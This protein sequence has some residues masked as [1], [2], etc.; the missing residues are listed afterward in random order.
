M[1]TVKMKF[2]SQLGVFT[3]SIKLLYQSDQSQAK[4]SAIKPYIAKSMQH[5]IKFFGQ[6]GLGS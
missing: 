3:Q 2:N 1:T 6:N 5:H 4:I